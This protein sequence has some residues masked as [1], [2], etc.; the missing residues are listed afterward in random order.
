VFLQKYSAYVNSEMISDLQIFS[1]GKHWA[2]D[3]LK[4]G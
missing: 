3:F 1:P 2:E 4:K